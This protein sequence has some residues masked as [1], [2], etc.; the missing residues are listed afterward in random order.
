MVSAA[1]LDSAGVRF[2]R[3]IDDLKVIHDEGVT[4]GTMTEAHGAEIGDRADG[5]RELEV[6]VGGKD[7]LVLGLVLDAPGGHDER[8]VLS[9][10]DDL[11]DTLGLE[12][13]DLLDVGWDVVHVARRSVGTGNGDN[14]DL[15]A[16]ESFVCLD[17]GGST[18][19][20]TVSE[21]RCPGDVREGG[22]GNLLAL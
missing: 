16:L 7:D 6:E 8:V 3:E 11:I 22:V 5:F 2:R 17:L 20:G 14:D 15:L 21:L 18:T 9:Q 12:A 4:A 1:N 10:N 13:V 19:S